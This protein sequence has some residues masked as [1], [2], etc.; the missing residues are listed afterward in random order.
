MTGIRNRRKFMRSPLL[1]NRKTNPLERVMPWA[2]P[3]AGGRWK[4]QAI[5]RSTPDISKR[6]PPTG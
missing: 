6:P 1:E 5:S 4:I 2:F 3:V